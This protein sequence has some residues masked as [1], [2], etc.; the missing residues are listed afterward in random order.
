MKNQSG[1]TRRAGIG[2]EG[3]VLVGDTATARAQRREEAGRNPPASLASQPPIFHRCLPS[4]K[5]N[6][7]AESKG[8]QAKASYSGHR[9]GH[10]RADMYVGDTRGNQRPSGSEDTYHTQHLHT[11]PQN[12]RLGT[13]LQDSPSSPAHSCLPHPPV[14]TSTALVCAGGKRRCPPCPRP[15]GKGD[16]ERGFILTRSDRQPAELYSQAGLAPPSAR[17]PVIKVITFLSLLLAHCPSTTQ[18]ISPTP[19]CQLFAWSLPTNAASPWQGLSPETCW[20][21]Y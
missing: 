3:T 17:S 10:G 1:S 6:Q 12:H 18:H 9:A 4:A 15:P 16:G 8:A 20:Q 19:D 21:M 5:P 11:K 13:R 7:K 14:P 2:E